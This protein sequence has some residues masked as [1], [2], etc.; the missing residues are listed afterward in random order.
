[1]PKPKKPFS[2][3]DVEEIELLS[4]YG[5]TSEQIAAV[6]KISKDTLERRLAY[7][8]DGC[9]ALEKG[10]ATAIKQVS[11]TAFRLAVSGEVPAM[12]MFYL[13][14]RARWRE[15]D[16]Q[17]IIENKADSTELAKALAQHL[18][19]L[20]D[21]RDKSMLAVATKEAPSGLIS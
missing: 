4:G 6:F 11:Q 5:L 21:E 15:K 10:R 1:M 17:I 12:T 14:C 16:D 8:P 18:Q 2:A 7:T 13:K 20:L 3:E 19:T 9:A